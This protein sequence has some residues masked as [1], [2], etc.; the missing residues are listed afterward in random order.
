M[1]ERMKVCLSDRAPISIR[2]AEWPVI[3]QAK[4]V[5]TSGGNIEILV[6]Q[7]EERSLVIVLWGGDAVAG[8][9]LYSK[10]DLIPCIWTTLAPLF[11]DRD[12]AK[13]EL[14]LSCIGSLPVEEV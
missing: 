5:S 7:N 11:H 14:A 6:R 9:L 3:A 1:S 2:T 4:H 10:A 12:I 8:R 13:Y